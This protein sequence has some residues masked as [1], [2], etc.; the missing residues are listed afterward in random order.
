MPGR[1]HVG[2]NVKREQ[3]DRQLAGKCVDGALG[4]GVDRMPRRAECRVDRGDVDDASA[5]PAATWVG[6]LQPAAALDHVP[7]GLLRTEE[8]P[9]DVEVVAAVELLFGDVQ[10]INGRGDTRVVHQPVETAQEGRGLIDHTPALADHLQIT[11]NG[12]RA[13][14]HRA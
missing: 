13:A 5:G 6:Q 9:A 8:L 7:D 3:L 14:A 11:L 12:D 10:E 2:P 4:A 1:E